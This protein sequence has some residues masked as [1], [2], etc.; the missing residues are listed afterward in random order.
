MRINQSYPITISIFS[1]FKESI[2][3]N[4]YEIGIEFYFDLYESLMFKQSL[5]L[6]DSL[7]N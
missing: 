2:L 3:N 5:D 1:V 7:I 4:K 6:D